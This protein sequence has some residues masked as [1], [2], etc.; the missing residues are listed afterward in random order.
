MTYAR[1]MR[2]KRSEERFFRCLTLFEALTLLTISNDLKRHQ[3]RKRQTPLPFTFQFSPFTLA[4][5]LGVIRIAADLPEVGAHRLLAVSGV[6]L[7]EEGLLVGSDVHQVCFTC[8]DSGCYCGEAG[9]SVK[10]FRCRQGGT[11][12]AVCIKRVDALTVGVLRCCRTVSHH[13]IITVVVPVG[14]FRAFQ[15]ALDILYTRRANFCFC[16]SR[17]AIGSQRKGQP[18]SRLAWAPR[19]PSLF[20][21]KSQ[22]ASPPL[23]PPQTAFGLVYVGDPLCRLRGV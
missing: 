15:C 23:S 19:P 21:A 16:H 12:V 22:L 2:K 7:C 11:F 4:L 3:T 18:H 9:T 20:E 5:M 1:K 10:L 13:Q 8:L 17:S 14:L 6:P